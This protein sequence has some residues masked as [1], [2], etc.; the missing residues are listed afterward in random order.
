MRST[1]ALGDGAS[2]M[3]A[4]ERYVLVDSLQKQ[5]AQE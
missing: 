2:G 1:S 5:E 4:M 3:T